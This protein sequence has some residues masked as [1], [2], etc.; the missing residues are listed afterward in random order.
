MKRGILLFVL[1]LASIPAFAGNPA[2]KLDLRNPKIREILTLQDSR[3]SERSRL[4]ALLHDA[5]PA[6]RYRAAIASANLQDTAVLPDLVG[7]IGDPDTEVVRAAAFAIGLTAGSLQGDARDSLVGTIFRIARPEVRPLVLTEAG[8]FVTAG[9]LRGLAAA[10]WNAPDQ[11]I[12]FDV[13]AA[14]AAIRGVTDSAVTRRLAL[15]AGRGGAV[16]WQCFYALQRIGS[17]PQS[18]SRIEAIMR[19]CSDPDPM[20][21]MQILLL[22]GKYQTTPPIIDTLTGY[23]RTDADWRVRVAAIRSLSRFFPDDT[24]TIGDCLAGLLTDDNPHV[25]SA[26]I[27]AVSSD[28]FPRARLERIRKITEKLARISARG[29]PGAPCGFRP[30]AASA[31]ARLVGKDAVGS[32]VLRDDPAPHCREGIITALGIAGDTAAVTSIFGAISDPDPGIVRA[33]LES[34]GELCTRNRTDMELRKTAMRRIRESLRSEDVAI[35]TTAAQLLGDSLFLSGENTGALLDALDRMKLPDDIEALQEVCSTLG[36][37]GDRRAVERL[38]KLRSESD[39]PAATAASGALSILTGRKVTPTLTGARTGAV[40]DL[41][42]LEELPDTVRVKIIT[43]RGDILVELYRGWAPFT[44]ANFVR[45]V[46]RSYF[47]NMIFHRVVPNFVIQGGDPRGDGWGGPGYTIRSE[48]SPETYGRGSIG[49]ASAGKD[50]EGS[51]FF[52][53]HSPQPHLDGRYTIFGCVR[54]GMDVVDAVQAG[55]AISSI[56]LLP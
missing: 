21:R 31:L 44:V 50:T 45:L 9:S 17:S 19:H 16:P 35:R 37:I 29:I 2:L 8:R 33:G 10:G 51:Q 23:A 26:A 15:S 14:R 28:D 49:M 22:L 48:F 34:I 46:N 55:D 12:P 30:E 40:P 25:A 38:E 41:T 1:V 27:T 18:E 53:T 3:S 24:G 54:K 32:I 6:V 47:R 5:E 43:P 56:V 7:L 36:K 11:E 4:I 52:I 39:P 42:L 20:V 13:A